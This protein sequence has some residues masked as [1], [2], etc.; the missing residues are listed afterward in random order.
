[1]VHFILTHKDFNL[2]LTI[3]IKIEYSDTASFVGWGIIIIQYSKTQQ[4]R[5]CEAKM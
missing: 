1:M 3:W 5:K 4:V 2:K